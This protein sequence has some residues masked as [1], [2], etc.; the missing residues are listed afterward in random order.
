M[1]LLSECAS[2]I[3]RGV[4]LAGMTWFRLGGAAR[5]MV[6]PSGVQELRES[7]QWARQSGVPVKI[8]G[9]GAN[10]LISDD[11][12]DGLVIRLDQPAF[13]KVRYDHD[14]VDAGA[15]ANLMILTRDCARR[16][17]SGLECMAGIPGTVGGAVTMN[18]GGRFGSF[19]NAVERVTLMDAEGNVFDEPA[20]RMNFGYRSSNVH[21]RIVLGAVIRVMPAPADRVLE[22]FMECWDYK[23]QSQPMAE[24]SAGCFFKNPPGDSAGRL[25]DA[26]GLKG[27]SVGQARVSTC[28]ANFL[29]A[30]HGATSGE[31]IELAEH[32]RRVIHQKTGIRLEFEIDVW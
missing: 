24:H 12:F 23:K 10:V 27:A 13:G 31:V 4:P 28:H 17:L 3:R 29:V 30:D 20:S 14:R 26:A 5:Y 11:G 2:S 19:G 32:V 1:S 9:A 8:L 18:A 15:G 21:D 25:I 6:S 22:R 16:G 7:L